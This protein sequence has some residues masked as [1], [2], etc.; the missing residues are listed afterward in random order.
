[1]SSG[2]RKSKRVKRGA[3]GQ[4]PRAADIRIDDDSVNDGSGVV[5]FDIEPDPEDRWDSASPPTRLSCDEIA[6]D[7]LVSPIIDAMRQ[8][9]WHRAFLLAAEDGVGF[10]EEALGILFKDALPDL[11]RKLGRELL[12]ALLDGDKSFP[13]RVQDAVRDAVRDAAKLFRRD[14]ETGLLQAFWEYYQALPKPLPKPSVVRDG[15]NAHCAHK[16]RKENFELNG[17]Q[18][19]ILRKA[20]LMTGGSSKHRGNK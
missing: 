8:A 19:S 6:N 18:W 12:L 4:Q 16:Y 2:K 3:A 14:R 1:M 10:G 17:R 11:E 5:D 7:S 20:V 15:F 13:R 9:G